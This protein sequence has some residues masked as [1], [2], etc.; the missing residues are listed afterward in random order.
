MIQLNGIAI[1][2]D[3]RHNLRGECVNAKDA[4]PRDERYDACGHHNRRKM[5]GNINKKGRS[6]TC[7]Q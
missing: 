1:D 2:Y 7:M 4:T 3:R 6:R 5:E